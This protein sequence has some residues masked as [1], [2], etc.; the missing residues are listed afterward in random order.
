MFISSFVNDCIDN[1]IV[2]CTTQVY[3]MDW[4]LDQ[5]M[6]FSTNGDYLFSTTGVL[7]IICLVLFV[8]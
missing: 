7:N 4:K 8:Y 2:R 3:E 6:L 1:L 5:Y